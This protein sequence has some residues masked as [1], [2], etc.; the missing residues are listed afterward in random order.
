MPR[1]SLLEYFR[2][3]SRPA[4]EPAVVWRRGYR[5]MRWSWADL[6]SAATQF[7]AE[8]ETRGIE[9]G[10][11]VLLWGENSGEWVAAF[12][13][14]LFHGAVSVPMDVAA[15]REFA[16]RVARQ[17]GVRLAVVGRGLSLADGGRAA[18]CLEDFFEAASNGRVRAFSPTAAERGDAVEIVFTSGTTAE[19]RG[20]RADARESP[21]ESSA[22]RK[23]D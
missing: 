14:C 2:V 19:P 7:A 6:L 15:D 8:L 5:T 17:A 10:D 18:L 22:H 3:D 13:G 12:L 23:G 1:Q 4:K 20:C 16:R 9:K 21:G 11:R